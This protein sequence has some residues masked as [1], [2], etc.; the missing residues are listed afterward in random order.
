MVVLF[1]LQGNLNAIQPFTTNMYRSELTK[2][3]A[4][5]IALEPFRRPAM[6][7]LFIIQGK[8]GG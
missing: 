6:A 5:T 7:V 8:M 2:R 3:R 1:N 4:K